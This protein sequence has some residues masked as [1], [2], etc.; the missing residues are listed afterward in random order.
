MQTTKLTPAFTTAN[1]TDQTTDSS[2][3]TETYTPTWT[4]DASPVTSTCTPSN[5]QPGIG[6]QTA[7]FSIGPNTV[8]CTGTDAFGNTGTGSFTVTLDLSAPPTI[9]VPA[10]MTVA[11]TSAKGAVVDYTVSAKDSGGNS[12]PVTCTDPSGPVTSGTTVF[13]IGA[14]TVTCTAT[15]SFDNTATKSFQV[16][17]KDESPPVI[18]PI[19]NVTTPA[20]GPSGAT[21][22]FSATATDLVDGTDPVT[23][24][25]SSGTV[26]SGTT[27]FRVGT[28]TV[29]CNATDTLGLK[30]TAVIFTV[31]VT[32][33]TP[34]V[35]AP[36]GNVTTPATTVAGATATFS[37]TATDLVDGTDPVTCTD[38]SGSVIS[39]TT[40]FPIGGPTTVTCKAKDHAGNSA[41]PVSFTVTITDPPTVNASSTTA[42]AT[43][44]TGAIVNYTVTATD[45]V[46]SSDS[47]KVD[48]A[49][50]SP[51]A[52]ST[53]AVGPTPVT[54]P[55]TDNH[56]SG[57]ISFTVTVTDTTDPVVNVPAPMTVA[58]T[59]ASGAPVSFTASATDL[60]DGA[61]TPTCTPASGSEFPVGT[62]TVT[63]TA[64]DAHGNS[65][66]AQFT[67][68][69]TAYTPP[70]TTTSSSSSVSSAAS[71]T[72][73][74]STTTTTTTTASGGVKGSTTKTAGTITIRSAKIKGNTATI[75]VVCAGKS[76]RC[77][78]TVE[79]VPTG[80][81]GRTVYAKHTVTVSGGK[82]VTVTLKLDGA[83]IA[84]T[85]KHHT[86]ELKIVEAGGKT[87][88]KT[89]TFG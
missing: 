51:A 70:S 78:L 65:A 2:G 59:S 14:T 32:D 74:T 72:S 61:L 47:V 21:A 55:Y 11:A 57:T 44:P 50:C 88:T 76:K 42:A 1:I 82:D 79:L 64:T 13:P 17:V 26:T 34:P 40:V 68:T 85:H 86:L 24:T 53:F 37:A 3:A 29:T 38:A 46:Q 10:N 54:C 8:R 67:I 48:V 25:D 31:D 12:L 66:S 58:P 89:V 87:A 75:V 16:T 62:T 22:T 27:V 30:A 45:P 81:A 6:P 36:I 69:V 84:D 18:A 5:S 4:D 23:C 7:S 9:T 15:D 35:I 80:R 20:T 63:C 73:T 39:G 43:G 52:D 83:G 33:L 49:S 60:V 77:P 71:T 19:A 28:T 56:G 41:T